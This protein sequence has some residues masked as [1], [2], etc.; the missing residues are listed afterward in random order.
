MN[1]FLGIL[2]KSRSYCQE[3]IAKTKV[4]TM[5]SILLPLCFLAAMMSLIALGEPSK[6]PQVPAVRFDPIIRTMEGWKVHIEPTL[7][8][9]GAQEIL[10][11]KALRMLGDHLN[12]I[13]IL[14]PPDRLEILQQM[15]IWIE[16][17]HPIMSSMQYHPGA[18]WLKNHGHDPRLHKKVHIPKAE[19][20]ISRQQL[21][22]HPAVILHE[23]AHA[24]HDQALGFDY[25]PVVKAY[26]KAKDAGLYARALL[27][28]G[29]NVRHY[30]LTNHK[31]FFAEGTE[32][33]FY[34]NDFYPFVRAE[35]KEYDPRFH[36]LLEQ[37]WGTTP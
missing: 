37:I 2:S 7:L 13:S 5:K 12:R 21:L 26:E 19:A 35:L 27:F 6:R 8:E 34:R 11:T 18:E 32:A 22:K 14:L 3:R 10:G 33:Y 15:E 20:L 23:L 30:G 28:T 17:D 9:G 36:D 29:A 31:E 25:A 16:Y 24:Y 1:T 4:A